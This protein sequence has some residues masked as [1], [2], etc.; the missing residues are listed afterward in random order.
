V[1]HVVTPEPSLTGRRV[2]C[3]GARGDAE[4]LPCREVGTGAA[5]HVAT[6]EPFRAGSGVWHHGTCGDARALPCREAVSSAMGHVVM[7]DP[8]HAGRRGL[9]PRD[10]W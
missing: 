3:H 6:L 4:A 5:R 8:S 1:G 10:T 7:L 9:A 2:W